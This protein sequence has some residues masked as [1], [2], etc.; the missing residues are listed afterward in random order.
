[1]RARVSPDLFKVPEREC[2][3]SNFASIAPDGEG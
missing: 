2:V 1:M 3:V